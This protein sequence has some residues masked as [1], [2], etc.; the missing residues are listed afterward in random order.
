MHVDELASKVLDALKDIKNPDEKR[1]QLERFARFAWEFPFFKGF[2]S[3]QCLYL[4]ASVSHVIALYAAVFDGDR[5]VAQIHLLSATLYG[6]KAVFS[7]GKRKERAPF[8]RCLLSEQEKFIEAEIQWKSKQNQ[9]EPSR[10]PSLLVLSRIQEAFKSQSAG[11]FKPDA[12]DEKSID[13]KSII[14]WQDTLPGFESGWLAFQFPVL[15]PKKEYL[16]NTPG[17]RYRC[18][19]YAVAL[20]LLSTWMEGRLS[21]AQEGLIFILYQ[22]A[23]DNQAIWKTLHLRFESDFTVQNDKAAL[24]NHLFTK[25]TSTRKD[26]MLAVV[27]QLTFSLSGSQSYRSQ[28]ITNWLENGVGS[29]FR[30]ID[31]YQNRT[32]P[33]TENS[34]LET[35]V[36]LSSC[37]QTLRESLNDAGNCFLDDNFTADPSIIQCFGCQNV[38][39]EG[40]GDRESSLSDWIRRGESCL[41]SA[42]VMIHLEREVGKSVGHY[43]AY[44]HVQEVAK[45]LNRSFPFVPKGTRSEHKP[46]TDGKNQ[47][48][49]TSSEQNHSAGADKTTERFTVW[50][51]LC[52]PFKLL[53]CCCLVRSKKTEDQKAETTETKRSGGGCFSWFFKGF[54]RQKKREGYDSIS[55]P[56]TPLK[57]ANGH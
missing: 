5:S 53:F 24:K 39:I 2:L 19:L 20:A 18:G 32:N 38:G 52:L 37:S 8:Q 26:I 44:T 10:G 9:D 28:K 30:P 14:V 13:E 41:V 33:S 42:P 17:I 48:I 36:T 21:E 16:I 4:S 31:C 40:G 43:S 35:A 6:M 49:S 12:V 29:D 23:L 22:A 51:C 54:R 15:E 46:A 56:K 25:A 45:A 3:K 55:D 34:L 27:G 11:T 47:K 7:S 50:S 57:Q 1:D